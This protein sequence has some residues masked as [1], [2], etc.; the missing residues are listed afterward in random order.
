MTD[1]SEADDPVRIPIVDDD[2][3]EEP[4]DD[5]RSA[6]LIML[7]LAIVAFAVIYLVSRGNDDAMEPPF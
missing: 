5:S 2:S 3:V 4:T 6:G 7:V 1:D